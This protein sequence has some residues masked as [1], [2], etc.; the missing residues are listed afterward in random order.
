MEHGPL[1]E[2]QILPVHWI[3]ENVTQVG[4]G[5]EKEYGLSV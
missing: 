1:L 2:P 3:G 5:G 4:L